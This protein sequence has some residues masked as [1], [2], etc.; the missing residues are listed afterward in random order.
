VG[1]PLLNIEGIE[2]TVEEKAFIRE[3]NKKG[4]I[5]IASKIHSAVYMPQSDGT[6]TGFH[7]SVLNEFAELVNVEIEVELVDWNAYFYKEGEDLEKVQNDPDYF[8]VP[9]LIEDVDLYIDGLTSL[10]WREKMFDII[11][12]VPSKQLVVLEK[13]N[14]PIQLKDL[15][16]KTCSV[17]K[18]TLHSHLGS[19]S[20]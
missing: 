8:Y 9:T 4:H 14:A 11:K 1:I 13:E 6:I 2:W 3:L 16:D 7:Y 10:P 18:D 5:D 12:F 19:S 15:N 20:L 17:V